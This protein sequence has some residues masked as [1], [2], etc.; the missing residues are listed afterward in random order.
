MFNWFNFFVYAVVTSITPGPNNVICMT[1]GKHAGIKKSLSFNFGVSLGV[2]V[3]LLVSAWL[4]TTLSH[5]IPKIRVPMTMIGAL[6]IL[7]L[8]FKTVTSKG[9]IIENNRNT[10]FLVG[11]MLQFI[12]PKAYIY[13]I[14][15]MEMY[16]LPFFSGDALRITLFAFILVLITFVS[17]FCWTSFGKLFEKLFSKYAKITNTI[18]ALLLVYCAISLFL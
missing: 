3:L 1:N 11:V 15:S 8:A 9:E 6:Y 2:F 5:F 7:Y 13:S 18:M 14:V 16:V 12:N 10:S 17:T 4:G